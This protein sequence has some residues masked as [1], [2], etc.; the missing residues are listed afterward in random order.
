MINTRPIKIVHCNATK[1]G[2]GVAEMLQSLIPELNDKGYHPAIFNSEEGDSKCTG[3]M[4]CAL[5]CPDV[6]IT[7]YK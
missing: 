7:V 2:G 4:T 1:E 3:C 6:C 5:M